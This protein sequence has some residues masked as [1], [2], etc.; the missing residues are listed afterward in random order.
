MLLH[1][2]H[3]MIENPEYEDDAE[4]Y[5]LAPIKYAG[6]EIWQVK[7]GTVFDNI[8]LTDD[9]AYARKFAEDTWGA[10]KAAEKEMFDA[11]QAEEDLARGEAAKQVGCCWH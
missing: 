1:A 4:V 6:F 2:Q 3:P 11:V 5:L 7:A 8:L 9:L 10:A